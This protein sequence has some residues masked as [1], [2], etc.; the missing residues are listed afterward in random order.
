MKNKILFLLN[1]LFLIGCS[2][3]TTL[4]LS[5]VDFNENANQYIDGLKFYSK[6]TQN[7]H[8]EIK[9]NKG[10]VAL[11]LVNNG[12]NVV[13]YVFTEEGNTK[14]LNY[15][16]LEIDKDLGAKISTY[17][18]KVAFISFSVDKNKVIDFI[19]ILKKD[20]GDEKDIIYNQRLSKVFKQSLFIDLSGIST[21]FIKKGKDDQGNDV[22]SYPQNIIWLKNDV[23]YQLTLDPLD[24]S[25]NNT[26]TI[27]T[28]K[29]LNDKVIFGYHNI[30]NDPLLKN[31]IN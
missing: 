5:K 8:F 7:G 27:I 1:S 18:D 25:I 17:Q 21:N 16:G 10:N 9:S 20:L 29:A 24:N 2:N 28:K 3:S 13:K 11:D 31:Y 22:I 26:L 15:Q 19:K 14:Q 23:I 12:E 6:E 30:S 4:D